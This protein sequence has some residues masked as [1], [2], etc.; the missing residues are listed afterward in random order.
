MYEVSYREN[1]KGV[2]KEWRFEE[3][4]QARAF[5][6]DAVRSLKDTS[7]VFRLPGDGTSFFVR[8]NPLP[9]GRRY[10]PV[11]KFTFYRSANTVYLGWYNPDRKD[12]WRDKKYVSFETIFNKS[13]DEVKKILAFHFDIFA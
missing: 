1:Y 5:Y 3:T 6:N 4:H 12:K 9:S 13:T 8:G 2:I 7:T 11:A 10:D